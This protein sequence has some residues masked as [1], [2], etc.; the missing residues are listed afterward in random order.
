MLRGRATTV[1]LTGTEDSSAL[2]RP[3]FRKVR[4]A[5]NDQREDPPGQVTKQPLHVDRV[6][7]SHVPQHPRPDMFMC[8]LLSLIR[9]GVVLSSRLRVWGG[10]IRCRLP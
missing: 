2:L 3:L 10:A 8:G 5:R 1:A 9:G 4:I 7:H 6:A